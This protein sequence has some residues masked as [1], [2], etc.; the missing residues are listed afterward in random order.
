MA[1]VSDHSIPSRHADEL[2]AV[3]HHEEAS[4]H[5]HYAS[6][7][8]WTFTA[9]EQVMYDSYDILISEELEK[10]VD[11]ALSSP[12]AYHCVHLTQGWAV[13]AP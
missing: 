1:A 10:L 7:A 6:T 13:L 8:K 12:Y 5:S 2:S 3:S 4:T 11:V 9:D